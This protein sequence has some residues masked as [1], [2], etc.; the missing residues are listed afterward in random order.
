MMG[1]LESTRD[2]AEVL[3]KLE[4]SI[5]I[6]RLKIFALAVALRDARRNWSGASGYE[7][8]LKNNVKIYH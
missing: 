7:L 6:L 4:K 2:S 8:R 5:N 3:P 1:R